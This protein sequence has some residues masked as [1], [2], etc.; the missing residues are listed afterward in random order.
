MERRRFIGLTTGSASMISLG[1]PLSG[2]AQ[3]LLEISSEDSR[4]LSKHKIAKAEVLEVNYRWPRFVGKNGRIDFHGQDHKSTVL[5]LYTDQGA[6]GWGLSGQDAKKYIPAVQ[7]KRVSELIIPGK[8]IIEGMD[9]SMDFALHD[10][11]GIILN[12]PVYQLVGNKGPKEA[13]VYSGMIYLDELNPGNESKSL[14]IILKNCEWDYNYGYRMLKVK[15]GRSGRWYPHQ[16]GLDKDIEVVKL[17]HDAYKGKNTQLLVDS[18][19]MY[20]LEDTIDFLK[21]INDVPLF[22]VEEPFREAIEPGRKL[23]EW[24]NKNGFEKTYYA[25]GEANPDY[26]VCMQLGKERVMDV[27]LDDVYSVGFSG[28]MKL[29]PKLKA[30]NM[31]ASPHAWGD[32]LKTHYAAH[33]SAGLGNITT[34]EGV[35]CLSDEIDYGNY[36]IINGMLRVSDAPGFGMKLLV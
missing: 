21:Q 3:Q 26:E 35:T 18:N 2:V 23:K 7:N 28:W 1:L 4:E 25:D 5:K 30:M 15:I 33:L 9:R 27:F 36:P 17:I 20:T 13:S 6:I 10:L 29:M 22:W 11:M 19:D 31:L 14:D 24:M 16:E 32:R 12:K 8:G 34:I